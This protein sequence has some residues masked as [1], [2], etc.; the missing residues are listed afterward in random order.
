MAKE[1]VPP[2]ARREVYAQFG[3]RIGGKRLHVEVYEPP[4]DDGAALPEV[5]KSRSR[6]DAGPRRRRPPDGSTQP[7]PTVRSLDKGGFP[8]LV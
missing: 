2:P 8:P 4:N 1:G 3:P 6:H 5:P 7:D